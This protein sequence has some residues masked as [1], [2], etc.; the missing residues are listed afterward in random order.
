MLAWHP[1]SRPGLVPD[2]PAPH[3]SSCTMAPTVALTEPQARVQYS[4]YNTCTD[5]PAQTSATWRAALHIAIPASS[6]PLPIN[7]TVKDCSVSIPT[8]PSAHTFPLLPERGVAPI[9][10]G[11]S[12][13]IFWLVSEVYSPSVLTEATL[14]RLRPTSTLR[15]WYVSRSHLALR[16]LRLLLWLRALTSPSPVTSHPQLEPP[17]PRSCSALSVSIRPPS[18]PNLKP[19]QDWARRNSGLAPAHS[20]VLG[21]QFRWA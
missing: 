15:S 4:M 3:D 13:A 16:V 11:F 2:D 20:R 18:A 6:S 17:Q 10:L 19:K 5:G 9:L 7:P 14:D 21:S 8:L 12:L 1:V